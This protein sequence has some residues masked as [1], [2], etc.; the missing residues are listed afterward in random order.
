MIHFYTKDNDTSK[1]KVRN[2]TLTDFLEEKQYQVN[3]ARYQI[4][5]REIRKQ[6]DLWLEQLEGQYNLVTN[7]C[8]HFSKWCTQGVWVSNQMIK[9]I[10][11]ALWYPTGRILL[12]GAFAGQLG[13][14]LSQL[15]LSIASTKI[16]E[17]LTNISQKGPEYKPKNQQE[18][19]MSQ[20]FTA[21]IQDRNYKALSM[22]LKTLIDDDQD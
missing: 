22:G 6:A 18:V 3:M 14:G 12:F 8:E 7:N 21:Y 10:H 16:L 17:W 5:Q 2:D 9:L 11:G 1:A 13:L 15:G 4:E 19:K 20:L